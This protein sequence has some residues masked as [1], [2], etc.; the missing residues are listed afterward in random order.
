MTT[1]RFDTIL[2]NWVLGDDGMRGHGTLANSVPP[3]R[4]RLLPYFFCV[5]M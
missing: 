5:L 2:S 3:A 1:R 4:P